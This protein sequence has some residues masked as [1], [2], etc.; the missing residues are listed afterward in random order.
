MRLTRGQIASDGFFLVSALGSGIA[1]AYRAL[2]S[3]G[4]GPIWELFI[5]GVVIMGLALV[6][7]W[8]AR[9]VRAMPDPPMLKDKARQAAQALTIGICLLVLCFGVILIYLVVN[10]ANRGSGRMD[11]LAVAGAGAA[12][13]LALAFLRMRQ[14]IGAAMATL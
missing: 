8:H 9:S 3:T 11:V 14:K 7:I 5:G 1:L 6:P 2:T 10:I 4:T 12:F 13:A